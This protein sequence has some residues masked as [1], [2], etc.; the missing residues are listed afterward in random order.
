MKHVFLKISLMVFATLFALQYPALGVS[1]KSGDYLTAIRVDREDG[2]YKLGEECSF[3]LVVTKDAKPAADL[4]VNWEVSKDGV[5]PFT[6]GTV[7]T[8]KDGKAFFKGKL[9]EPGFVRC[10]AQ[11]YA[12]DIKTPIL[13]DAGAAYAPLE[14]KPSLPVPDDFIS[15]WQ[16]Q[17]E[18]LNA[19]PQNLKLTPVE[20]KDPSVLLFDVQADVL[21]GKLS[22]YMAYPKNAANKSLPA[23]VSCHGA[24]VRGSYPNVPVEWAKLGFIAIDFN[25]LGLPNGQ[26]AKFYSDLQNGELKE[27]YLKGVGNRDKMFFRFLYMRLLRAMQVVTEQAQWDGKILVAY[28]RSQGGGQAIVA[29]GLDDRVTFFASHIAA[30][31]DHSGFA[32]KRAAGW[33]RVFT[34]MDENGNYDKNIVEEARY[35]DAMNFAAITKA[36]SFMS[37]GY[38]DRVCP[39]TTTYAAYNALKGNK[40]M[41]VTVDMGHAASKEADSAAVKAVLEHVKKM[42]AA[43]NN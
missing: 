20:T 14:I 29:A 10:T 22:G 33:P 23:L 34:A 31:C 35:I 11:V 12:P 37:I 9:D 8:D 41:F 40:E 1:R 38:A 17:K 30:L 6:K 25:A 7:K 16:K 13:V 5:A 42:R 4:K 36:D 32:V 43:S 2:T 27:Y 18:I 3:T 39:P 26:P 24:G 19:I 28:G 15:Y 21:D